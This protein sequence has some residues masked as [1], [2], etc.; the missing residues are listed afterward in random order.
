MDGL[1]YSDFLTSQLIGLVYR[2][3]EGLPVNTSALYRDVRLVEKAININFNT[4]DID[5]R[6][7]FQTLCQTKNIAINKSKL[8]VRL[9]R[10]YIRNYKRR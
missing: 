2:P 7:N 9:I 5:Y 3:A 4:V 1:L 10:L 6:V 8:F